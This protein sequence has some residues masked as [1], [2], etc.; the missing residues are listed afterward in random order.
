MFSPLNIYIYTYI[1][2]YR[3]DCFVFGVLFQVRKINWNAVVYFIYLFSLFFCLEYMSEF[4]CKCSH[5]E[6][7]PQKHV[8]LCLKRN[9]HYSVILKPARILIWRKWAVAPVKIKQN[10]R[11]QI[12]HSNRIWF[13]ANDYT[14]CLALRTLI[15]SKWTSHTIKN[16]AHHLRFVGSNRTFDFVLLLLMYW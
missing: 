8:R 15:T 16:A 7:T 11:D 6:H 13:K 2:Q 14:H 10:R 4:L 3:S 12:D 5:H 1:P 9:E